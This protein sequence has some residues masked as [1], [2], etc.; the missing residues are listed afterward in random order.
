MMNWLSGDMQS[1]WHES[2]MSKSWI[3]SMRLRRSTFLLSNFR[4]FWSDNHCED[5]KKNSVKV[6]ESNFHRKKLAEPMEYY[7]TYVGQRFAGTQIIDFHI[8]HVGHKHLAARFL[9]TFANGKKTFRN[10]SLS[11]EELHAVRLR[12]FTVFWTPSTC[13]HMRSRCCV[14]SKCQDYRNVSVTSTVTDRMAALRADNGR[15][16]FDNATELKR[17]SVLI[18]IVTDITKFQ[19]TC[20]QIPQTFG[21]FHKWVSMLPTISCYLMH[22]GSLPHN[23]IAIRLGYA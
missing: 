13:V 12:L 23:S 14:Y 22:C 9:I 10:D 15:I 20:I 1:V 5:L 11:S 4:R 7:M 2:G 3:N 21:M 16:R 6:N 17:C 18:V 8:V 19:R